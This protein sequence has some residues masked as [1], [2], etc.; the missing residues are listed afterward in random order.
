MIEQKITALLNQKFQEEGFEDCFLVE[1]KYHPNNK[2]DVFID[3]DGPLTFERCQRIS[4]YLESFIDE[5]GWLGEKYVLEVS[6]PG[7]TR[8]LK[9]K[10]QYVKNIGRSVKVSFLTHGSKTGVLKAVEDDKIIIEE[11]VII[12]DK[13]KKRKGVVDVEIPFDNI[14]KAIVQITF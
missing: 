1:L 2:L 13:K 8:P 14:S 5:E 7:I 10:R 9:L 4:R 6:S 3:S 12:K 11:E